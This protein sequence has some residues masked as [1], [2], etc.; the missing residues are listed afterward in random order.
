MF[1]DLDQSPHSIPSSQL[2]VK[3]WIQILI[4]VNET[5]GDFIRVSGILT[6]SLFHGDQKARKS[7]LLLDGVVLKYTT[8]KH[9]YE[10]SLKTKMTLTFK[11]E[12]SSQTQRDEAE[13]MMTS[14]ASAYKYAW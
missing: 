4:R 5:W 8:E 2:L 7:S 11:T 13:T 1:D 14:W 10:E 3:K 9:C 6:P 12:E